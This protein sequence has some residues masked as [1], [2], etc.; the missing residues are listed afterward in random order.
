MN[1]L[2]SMDSLRNCLEG[3]VPSGIA[4][5]LSRVV[6]ARVALMGSV[7]DAC[8]FPSGDTQRVVVSGPRTW[9]T[10]KTGLPS[11]SVFGVGG[12]RLR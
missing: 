11:R 1:R 12:Q 5:A 9:R 8:T 10:S 3:V 2:I 6:R 7:C 4:T